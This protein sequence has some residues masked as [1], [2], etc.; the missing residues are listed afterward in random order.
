MPP[1][2]V[3]HCFGPFALDLDSG[4]LYRGDA[5]VA[6]PYAQSRILVRLVAAAPGAVTK[7]ALI[8]EGWEGAVVSA[9]NLDKAMSGLRKTLGPVRPRTRSRRRTGYIET[10]PMKGYRF[11][12]EVRRALR[13]PPQASLDAQI[14]P[15]RTLV[16]ARTGIESL[17]LER[18]QRLRPA[19]EALLREHPKN[20]DGYV[21]LATARGLMYEATTI[22]R[23]PDRAS[24][25][26]GLGYARTGCELASESGEAWSTHAL[27]LALAGTSHEAAAAAYRAMSLEPD[28]WRH[29]LRAGYVT[30]GEER[31]R[32]ASRALSLSPGRAM[33]HWLRATV[34]AARRAFPAARTEVRAG[35][36]AQDLQEN[37]DVRAVGLHLL[38]GLLLA[39][40]GQLDAAIAAL[41]QELSASST[42]GQIYARQCTANTW[43]ALGALYLRLRRRDEANAAF[44]NALAIAP[45]HPG[46]IAALRGEL[47]CT[48][49]PFHLALA[50]AVILARGGRHAEAAAVYRQAVLASPHASDG[51]LLPVDPMLN[52]A[53]H[54]EIW[55]ETLALIG[56]R[57]I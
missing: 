50:H 29:A 43:H 5:R 16:E 19:L 12:A 2:L 15:Y 53:A 17:D 32:A 27:L 48:G 55:A 35:C 40:E 49:T 45:N 54:P 4:S 34:F 3:V 22:D 14:A 56:R 6:L 18:I 51:W 28:D 20:A 13:Q 8:E 7:E 1:G 37:G 9:N 31:L 36:S 38:D 24:L 25:M 46:A 10:L 57:A 44:A 39:A 23:E 33:A 52:P 41:R 30:W 11:A 47:P 21:L 42:S 26:A